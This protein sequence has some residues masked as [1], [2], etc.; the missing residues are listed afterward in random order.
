[1]LPIAAL[2]SFLNRRVHHSSADPSPYTNGH[3]SKRPVNRSTVYTNA[4]LV[5]P[6]RSGE[7]FTVIDLQTR[8]DVRVS[9]R[10][11]ESGGHRPSKDET[12]TTVCGINIQN[13]GDND[14]DDDLGRGRHVCTS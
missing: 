8:C 4:A 2:H 13:S 6:R 14:D 3:E 1:M 12:A 10:I 7:V 5:R 11:N 9:G